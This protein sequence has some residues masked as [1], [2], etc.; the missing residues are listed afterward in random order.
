MECLGPMQYKTMLDF[1]AFGSVLT[2]MSSF[3]C[4]MG[5]KWMS[6]N[7][8]HKIIRDR[9]SEGERGVML[10]YDPVS[11]FNAHLPHG[12]SEESDI[13]PQLSKSHLDDLFFCLSLKKKK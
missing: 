4:H 6:E 11:S 7:G 3:H 8:R 13:T 2:C 12:S 9:Q 10:T 1:L 5:V